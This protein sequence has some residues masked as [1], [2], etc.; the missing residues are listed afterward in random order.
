MEM[1]SAT[2]A[3]GLDKPLHLY[4]ALGF[5]GTKT[6]FLWGGKKGGF[7][8]LGLGAGSVGSEMALLLGGHLTEAERSAACAAA[9][10]EQNTLVLRGSHFMK[11]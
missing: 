4:P 8:E 11:M 9:L 6:L 3:A 2:V 10:V 1:V 5:S 7:S